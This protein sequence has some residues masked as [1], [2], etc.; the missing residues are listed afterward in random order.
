M[1]SGDPE[2]MAG[3]SGRGPCDDMR[4]KPDVVAPGTD[5]ASA[6]SSTSDLRNFWG[7][8]PRS[9]HY[10]LMGGTSMACPVATGI[11]ALVREY[12]RKERHH[13]PSAALVKATVINGAR[14]LS[15]RDA[16]APPGGWPNYHQGFGRVDLAASIPDDG[17]SVPSLAFADRRADDSPLSGTGD[18][19]RF[20]L[21]VTGSEELRICL[22]WNDVPG[23][24]LQNALLMQF[25]DARGTVWNSNQDVHAPITFEA[26]DPFAPA[27]LLRRDPNNNVHLVRVQAPAI[28][29]C[30]VSV[31]ADNLLKGPQGFALVVT[32]MV[33]DL[34]AVPD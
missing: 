9:R 15:G 13:V 32:G 5:I 11:A 7:P 24:N 20:A 16:T 21:D 17:G 25:E 29:A 3:F 31:L 30:L 10:A 33:G 28:G 14:R 19:A 26:T 34:V 8:Y 4:V 6:K 1:V 22:V 27:A 12:Y 18:V 23:R 2:S